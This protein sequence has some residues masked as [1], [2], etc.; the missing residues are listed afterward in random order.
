MFVRKNRLKTT[1]ETTNSSNTQPH[2]TRKTV[3]L[4]KIE[5]QTFSG[6]VLEWASFFDIFKS[7]IHSDTTLDNIQ[8]FVYLRS[9]LK[10]EAART[11]GGLTLT[12]A[13]YS[14]A[15]EL[16]EERYGQKHQI[17]DAHMTALLNLSKPVD[18]ANI[19]KAMTVLS[20]LIS[21]F[22]VHSS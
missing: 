17:I 21:C 19:W 7:S 1:P 12:D 4:P 16:L 9:M 2:P 11:V 10:D 13:N 22:G 20:S 8:K 18:D 15:I 3:A 5:L 6:N 14:H